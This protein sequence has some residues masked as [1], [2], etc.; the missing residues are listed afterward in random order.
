MYLIKD[1]FAFTMQKT[2]IILTDNKNFNKTIFNRLESIKLCY[3]LN[4]LFQNIYRINT[5]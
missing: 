3:A 2:F 5:I 4:S 1:K